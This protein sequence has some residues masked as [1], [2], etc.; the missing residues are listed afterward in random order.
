MGRDPMK[1]L[2]VAFGCEPGRG[3]EPGV[4]WG[5]VDEA[6]RRRP[7]WVITHARHRAAMDQYLAERHAHHPIRP[8][9]VAL[10]GLGWMWRTH[11]G[12]NVYYYLWQL[13]AGLVGRRLNRAVGGFD[14][15]HHVS[16][17]RYWMHTAGA[18]VGAPLVFGPVGGGDAW[19]PAFWDEL[20][21]RERVREHYWTAV[22]RVMEFDPLLRRTLRQS[23]AT[24]ASGHHAAA[25]LGRLGVNPAG[26]MSA[27][28]PTP[29]LPP[30]GPGPGP[31]D[32][33]RFVSIG[34]LPRWRGV[35]LGLRAFA[36][37]FGPAAGRPADPNVSYSVIGEGSDLPRL[38]ALA[39]ELGIADRVRF[40]GD[41]PYA[42]CL[43]HLAAAGAMVHPTLRDSAGVVF[44]A[45][46]LGVPVACSDI[47]TPPLLV[48]DT[49]GEVIPTAGGAA[50][51]V[52]RM[53]A[54]MRRWRAMGDDYGRLRRGAVE[55]A[56]VMS[57]AGRGDA[58]DAVYARV[59]AD[60]AAAAPPG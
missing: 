42:Q 2:F 10:P 52:S 54:T 49:C 23:R 43:E 57:R 18:L 19:P 9:Y 36:E 56:A 39:R 16:F 1:L 11:L 15:V 21:L 38:K 17:T 37:A 48:D 45:L 20:T 27:V 7:V 8:V 12:I 30:V 41:L 50:D 13:K 58:M 5:F 3:S 31:G 44:E 59:M 35:H 33:F 25:Q 26:V 34:R 40:E 29:E 22:R 51:L 47:G 46:S 4:G 32:V 6:S 60:R 24:L 14:V 55:R 28:A 53:A